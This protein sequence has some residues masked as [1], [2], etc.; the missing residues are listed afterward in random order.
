MVRFDIIKL[1]ILLK[2]HAWMDMTLIFPQNYFLGKKETPYIQSLQSDI[3]NW[4][5]S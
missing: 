2:L 4:A 1:L 3:F 5:C